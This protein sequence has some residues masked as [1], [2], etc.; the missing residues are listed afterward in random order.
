[1]TQIEEIAYGREIYKTFKHILAESDN[2]LEAL[3]DCSF[4][5]YIWTEDKTHNGTATA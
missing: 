2:I 5:S 1:M 3:N 4:E